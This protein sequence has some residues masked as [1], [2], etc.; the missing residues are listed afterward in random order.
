M[1]KVA[2][3]CSVVWLRNSLA[4]LLQVGSSIRQNSFPFSQGR[5]RLGFCFLGFVRSETDSVSLRDADE[6]SSSMLNMNCF[7]LDALVL[8]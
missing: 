7:S 5:V 6:S 3:S 2:F 8:S 1:I 4:S